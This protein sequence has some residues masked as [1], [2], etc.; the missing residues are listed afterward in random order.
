MTT[1]QSI[2]LIIALVVIGGAVALGMYFTPKYNS[3]PSPIETFDTGSTFS[4]KIG[5]KKGDSDVTVRP[6]ELLEDSRCPLNVQC[7]QAG[8]VRVRAEIVG[9]G[10]TSIQTFTLSKSIS[11]GTKT[12]TLVDV[13][14]APIAGAE[15]LPGNYAFIFTV[16]K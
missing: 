13:T 12:I 5:D 11:V 1:R 4:V 15:K 16:K 7:I 6:T 3:T 14:P 10:T 8:T 2:F 9:M